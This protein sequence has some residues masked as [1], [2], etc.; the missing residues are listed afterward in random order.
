M[1]DSSAIVE[2]CRLGEMMAKVYDLLNGNVLISFDTLLSTEA[3]SWIRP[4]FELRFCPDTCGDVKQTSQARHHESRSCHWPGQSSNLRQRN[5][6]FGVNAFP[7]AIE[8]GPF[9]HCRLT[10]RPVF[11]KEGARKNEY[12]EKSLHQ[13]CR[14]ALV[15]SALW[16][17]R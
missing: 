15:V 4:C 17:L 14:D 13:A 11:K 5:S 7:Q 16:R 3:S 2:R 10:A 6:V 9:T 12:K 1:T 8:K